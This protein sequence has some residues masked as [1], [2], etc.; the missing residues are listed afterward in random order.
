M[1]K[2][3]ALIL[4]IL[5]LATSLTAVLAVGASADSG[6]TAEEEATINRL[7]GGTYQYYQN[8]VQGTITREACIK[9]GCISK[10]DLK[11]WRGKAFDDYLN[12][13]KPYASGKPYRDLCEIFLQTAKGLDEAIEKES[14]AFSWIRRVLNIGGCIKTIRSRALQDVENEVY[15]Q[16]KSQ[17]YKDLGNLCERFFRW[18]LESC[19]RYR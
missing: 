18:A 16:I 4:T 1:K 17:Y 6:F 3:I 15:E 9:S 10:A 13:I 5:T 7:S 2:I 19:D 11:G 12:R 8:L 14:Q